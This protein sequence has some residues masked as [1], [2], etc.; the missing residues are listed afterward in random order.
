MEYTSDQYA[1][2]EL[3]EKGLNYWHL[4]ED[5]QW[6]LRYLQDHGIAQPKAYI[7]DGYYDLS[8]TGKRIL[9]EHKRMESIRQEDIRREQAQEQ[10]HLEQA[11]AD[12]AERHAEKRADRKFQI[13]LSV[14]QALLT[15]VIGLLAEYFFDIIDCISAFFSDLFQSHFCF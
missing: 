4:L 6:T 10:K 5:Q 1:L 3:L 14:L 13:I 15:L 7:A 2:M 8:E 9:E 11:A 12:K